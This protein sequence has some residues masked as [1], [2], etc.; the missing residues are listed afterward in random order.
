MCEVQMRPRKDREVFFFFFFRLP[1]HYYCLCAKREV[2]RFCG[3]R[4]TQL[5]HF[6]V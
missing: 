6:D 5:P 4:K 2:C 1:S 3:D